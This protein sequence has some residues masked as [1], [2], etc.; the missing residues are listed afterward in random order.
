MGRKFTEFF[1]ENNIFFRKEVNRLR[2]K[3][4]GKETSE[5]AEVGR[6]LNKKDAVRRWTGYLEK[7]C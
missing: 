6:M 1:Q 3:K 5:K 2:K 7:D 4:P